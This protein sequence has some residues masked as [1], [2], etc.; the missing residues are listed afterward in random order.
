MRNM[1]VVMCGILLLGA[2]TGNTTPTQV[3]SLTAEV[4]PLPPEGL[5]PTGVPPGVIL[6]GI[7]KIEGDNVVFP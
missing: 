1:M 3:G 4:I 6:P 7:C 5:M 2:C